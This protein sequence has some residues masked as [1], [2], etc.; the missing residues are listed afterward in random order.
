MVNETLKNLVRG[1]AAGQI[2]KQEYRHQRSQLIDEITA[3][4]TI[5]ERTMEAA[6]QTATV[7]ETTHTEAAA[8]I[9]RADAAAITIATTRPEPPADRL[10]H[11]SNQFA[12]PLH[13]STIRII[14]ISAVILAVVIVI[15][16]MAQSNNNA[17]PA[18]TQASNNNQYTAQQLAARFISYDEWTSER[19]SEFVAGWQRLPEAEKEQARQT[20][21]FQDLI[22]VM[23]DRLAEQQTLANA[24]S[25]N[26]RQNVETINS[27]ARLLRV[28][29]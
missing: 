10:N 11:P 16:A 21:W 4:H 20:Q 13:P 24:G 8:V 1:Y 17:N 29:L 26:A 6:E 19:V 12:I 7:T 5:P 2:N 15:G 18:A 27:V 14:V 28:S 3:G 22:G 23:R 25:G 9:D